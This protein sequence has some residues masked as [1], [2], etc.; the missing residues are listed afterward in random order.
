MQCSRRARR[1][2]LLLRS[3]SEVPADAMSRARS[4][5][6]KLE[7]SVAGEAMTPLRVAERFGQDPRTFWW[8]LTPNWQT[9]LAAY[10]SVRVAEECRH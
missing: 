1:F 6:P 10:E 7:D 2:R 4:V 9:L 5:M 3:K 8:G